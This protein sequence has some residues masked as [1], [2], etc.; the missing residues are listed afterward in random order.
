MEATA[1]SSSLTEFF[2]NYIAGN[3]LFFHTGSVEVIDT[4]IVNY[5]INILITV[6]GILF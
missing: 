2:N 1:G 6:G 3:S 5:L 4:E